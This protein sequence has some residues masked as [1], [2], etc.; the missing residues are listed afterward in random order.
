MDMK[1]LTFMV[2]WCIFVNSIVILD[3]VC[4]KYEHN[5]NVWGMSWL[6]ISFWMIFFG[7]LA[8]QQQKPSLYV[9]RYA[10]ITQSAFGT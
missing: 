9:L 7:E 10:K 4:S 1:N 2:F 8:I 3:D 6:M 5:P